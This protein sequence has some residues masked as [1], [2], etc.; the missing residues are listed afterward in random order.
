[1]PGSA[2]PRGPEECVQRCS[3]ETVL[4]LAELAVH[5]HLALFGQHRADLGLADGPQGLL[6]PLHRAAAAKAWAALAWA[7][8]C[9]S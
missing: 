6:H 9:T 1:M 4:L 7:A 5:L 8:S 2:R 3:V